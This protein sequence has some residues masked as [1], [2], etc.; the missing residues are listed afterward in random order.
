[1]VFFICNKA[2]ICYSVVYRVAIYVIYLHRCIYGAVEYRP[3]YSVSFE[4]NSTVL[5]TQV[6][7]MTARCSNWASRVSHRAVRGMVEN[8]GFV[9]VPI[10]PL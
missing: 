10:K 1:M 6:S 8:P 3:R 4:L 7:T 9:V 5:Y 2:K